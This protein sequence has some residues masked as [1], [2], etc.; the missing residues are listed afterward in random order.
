MEIV[1]RAGW[2]PMETG[3]DERD[4]WMECIRSTLCACYART[5][6]ILGV[7]QP[8]CCL[9]PWCAGALDVLNQRMML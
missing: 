1:R 3:S 4:V 5:K 9:H 6:F 7:T 8:E 2:L